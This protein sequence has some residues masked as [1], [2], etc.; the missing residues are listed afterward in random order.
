VTLVSDDQI[1]R[2]H[3]FL[4]LGPAIPR[5]ITR[6]TFGPYRPTAAGR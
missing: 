2:F 3:F 6:Q 5:L 4:L 1:D